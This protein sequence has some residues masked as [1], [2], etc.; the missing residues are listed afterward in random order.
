MRTG[1][2]PF[3]APRRMCYAAYQIM[4]QIATSM[5]KYICRITSNLDATSEDMPNSQTKNAT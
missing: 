3:I 5:P 1:A 4:V 2:Q